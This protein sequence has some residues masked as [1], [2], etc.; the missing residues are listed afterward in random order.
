MTLSQEVS[1]GQEGDFR[2]SLVDLLWKITLGIVVFALVALSTNVLSTWQWALLPILMSASSVVAWQLLRR[3]W[4]AAASWAYVLLT[5]L[6]IHLPI[7]LI[8][9]SS[10]MNATSRVLAE[11][12]PFASLIIISLSGVLLPA[13]STLIL[14]GIQVMTTMVTRTRAAVAA[15]GLITR[16]L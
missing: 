3:G 2:L 13:W 10:E 9:P 14:F 15:R 4:L 5:E 12:L 1:R 11:G 7:V 6:A 16:T 8:A